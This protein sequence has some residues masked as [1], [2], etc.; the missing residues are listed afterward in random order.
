[1]APLIV[2]LGLIF[3]ASFGPLRV[4]PTRYAKVSVN[5]VIAKII[6]MKINE[7]YFIPA[8]NSS[9]WLKLINK[10]NKKN[11]SLLYY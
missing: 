4:L 10:Q 1:M 6:I 3:G 5:Q 11:V 8:W 9:V 2:L 7:K